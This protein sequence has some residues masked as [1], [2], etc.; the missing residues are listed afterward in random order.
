MGADKHQILAGV[1]RHA[2][3]LHIWLADE[4]LR[5]YLNL[6]RS[7]LF[8]KG[9]KTPLPLGAD[10]LEEVIAVSIKEIEFC[11]DRRGMYGSPQVGGDVNNR[12]FPARGCRHPQR[13]VEGSLRGRREVGGQE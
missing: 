2:T 11:I 3:D 5:M 4:E 8:N 13:L 10:L 12:E 1:H 9:I 6:S 7:R